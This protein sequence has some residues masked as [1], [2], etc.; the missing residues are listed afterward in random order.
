MDEDD[1]LAILNRDE[2]AFGDAIRDDRDEDFIPSPDDDEGS[3]EDDDGEADADPSSPDASSGGAEDMISP[4]LLAEITAEWGTNAL[5][6]SHIAPA[7]QMSDD[8]CKACIQRHLRM[9]IEGLKKFAKGIKYDPTEQGSTYPI[10]Y[11]FW[12]PLCRVSTDDLMA[13][14]MVSLVLSLHSCYHLTLT[15]TLTLSVARF[16]LW[17]AFIG[18]TKFV[19]ALLGQ[20][21]FPSFKSHH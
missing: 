14:Y 2:V 1:I 3:S 11:S 16:L 10:S 7:R 15:V 20:S 12:F 8:R 19:K 21:R 5:A 6:V 13:S 18:N 4:H 17:I 9:L